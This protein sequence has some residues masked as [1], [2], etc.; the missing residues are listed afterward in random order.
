MSAGGPDFSISVPKNG[1]AW[2]YVDALSDDGHHGLTII[3][4]IGSVF[5]PYYAWARQRGRG[6]PEH[7]CSFNVALY[8]RAGKRWAMTERGRSSL[9]RDSHHIAIGPSAMRW[10][11]SVL[12]IN[13][14]ETTVPLPS[15]LL[16]Q[17]KVHSGAVNG[18]SFSL[19]RDGDHCWQPIMPLARVDVDFGSRGLKWSGSGYFD[20]NQGVEPL[21]KGFTSWTWCRSVSKNTTTVFYD[22]TARGSETCSDLA[23]NIDRDGRISEAERPVVQ[24]L[25]RSKWL[26]PRSTRS[27][28]GSPPRII[29]TLEDTPFYARSVISASIA[30]EPTVMVHESLSL[31]RFSMPL[32]QAMLPFKMPRRTF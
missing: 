16:G 19:R 4:F 28:S 2:W 22:M 7:H 8:G 11:G 26:V 23:I 9:R 25:P 29:E 20:H 21:E 6:D 10:D 17:V 14:D 5:S 30:G 13:I 1:Y 27:D 3:A 31:D 15:R 12:T 32:V 24:K 18:K